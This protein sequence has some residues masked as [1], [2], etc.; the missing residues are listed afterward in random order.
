MT[1]EDDEREA[2][3]ILEPLRGRPVSV[4]DHAQSVDHLEAV[5]RLARLI[6]AVPAERETLRK[7]RRVRGLTYG[8]AGA[9]SVAAG[10]W[11]WLDTG[12]NQAPATLAQVAK[13]RLER[14]RLSHAGSPLTP[15]VD[16]VIATLG[17]VST[18]AASGAQF[19][20][21]EGMRVAIAADSTTDLGFSGSNRRLALKRGR[22]ELSVPKLAA[23]QSVSVTTPDA[24]VTVHGT[25]FSVELRDDRTCVRV[26]EGTVSVARG[27]TV[28]QLR[29]GQQSGCEE[30]GRAMAVA[31]PATADQEARASG[32]SRPAPSARTSGVSRAGG[33]L[34]EE[35]RL[36]RSALAAEQAGRLAQ[37]KHLAERL[38][39][40]YPSSPMVPEARRILDRVAVR[41]LG[42]NP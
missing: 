1:R 28:T 23:D 22:V 3:R 24:V 35:N 32:A 7:R 30:D 20:T 10:A 38:V 41:N 13:L 11:A 27:S 40:N 17:R 4:L 6:E 37:A 18:P 31:V 21:D 14:G 12:V 9:L 39:A 29:P 26:T 15:G 2:R 16:Y 25:R 5:R 19:V 36:F 42:S 34:T 33:T 8:L